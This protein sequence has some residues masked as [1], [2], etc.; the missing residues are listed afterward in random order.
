M[1]FIN[2]ILANAN[3]NKETLF[4]L[5]VLVTTVLFVMTVGYIFIGVNSPVKRKLADLSVG[6]KESH[7]SANEKLLNRLESLAPLTSSSNEKERNSTRMLLM[8]AGYHQK[9]SLSL[10]Y[11]I[12]SLTTIIGLV[13]AMGL[14]ILLPQSNKLY[15]YMA[16]CVFIGL[17]L[18]DILLKRMVKKRQNRI[19]SGVADMLDLLVVCTESG[20]GFNASLRRVANEMVISHPEL[21]EELDTVCMKIQAGKSMPD[22]LREMIVRTGLE[23]FLGLVS[24]LSHASRVGGSLVDSLREYTE[25]YRD[26]RQQAAEEIAAKIPVK[27]MFPMVIFIWPCF[28][29][30]AIGPSLITLSEAFSGG[31]ALG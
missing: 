25:D 6:Q 16:A 21:A 14:Y 15:I 23:E 31:N 24:M 3:I 12:K 20:L 10:F 11:S 2:N 8:H 17:I 26:K 7:S 13:I 18:P 27:M 30:V 29:I 22:S 1:E 4:M 5:F 9:N 19:R 28:F